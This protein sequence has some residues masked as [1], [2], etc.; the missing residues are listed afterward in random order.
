MNEKNR[1]SPR[2]PGARPP[3]DEGPR[4]PTGPDSPESGWAA[5][6]E[7]EVESQFEELQAENA[8]LKDKLLRTMA[9]MENLLRRTERE[10][11]D[12][13]KYAI[14]GFAR[15][16]LSI[17]DNLHRA[18]DAVPKDA[19]ADDPALKSLMDGVEVT[20]RELLNML[21][22]HGIKQ[23]VPKGERFDPNFHQAMLE[24]ENPNMDAGTVAEVVQPGYV[25]E[26]RVLRPAMVAVSKGGPKRPKPEEPAEM[27]QAAN[28]D[29]PPAKPSGP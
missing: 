7:A 5:G 20:E 9:D 2:K 1:E 16:V 8:E 15:D 26:D 6:E 17:G 27:P 12:T 18:I 19:I 11:S 3:R 25:I 22:R 21:E 23:I 24:I 10:K 13:A 14:S 29:K 4:G 28:D